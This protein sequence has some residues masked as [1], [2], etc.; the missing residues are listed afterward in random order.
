MENAIDNMNTYYVTIKNYNRGNLFYELADYQYCL[1]RIS[2]FANQYGC[3]LHA[4]ALMPD[5]VHLLLTSTRTTAIITA[6]EILELNYGEYFNFYH[7]RVN[8]LLELDFS[9]LP[10][11]ADQHLL[12]YC[13]YIELAPV[14]AMLMQHPADYHWSSYGFNAMGEDTGML[15]PHAKYLALGV[16][17]QT[18]RSC[19]RG[20]FVEN[21]QADIPGRRALAR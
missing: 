5:H 19:Y 4:Y 13:R 10:V 6:L 11:D 9:I 7:R 8:R 12:M 14:R 18:R 17:E 15:A 3:Q 16:D 2:L 21:H 20:L 1:S